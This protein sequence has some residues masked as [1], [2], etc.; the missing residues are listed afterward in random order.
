MIDDKEIGG[1]RD[2]ETSKE[3]CVSNRSTD[4]STKRP[5]LTGDD[6]TDGESHAETSSEHCLSSKSTKQP[7]LIF[8]DEQQT[9]SD[10]GGRHSPMDRSPSVGSPQR[11]E[12]SKINTHPVRRCE[13]SAHMADGASEEGNAEVS[14][15]VSNLPL[16]LPYRRSREAR[17]SIW[18]GDPMITSERALS[19]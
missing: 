5:R 13:R 9:P 15:P 10:L 14:H 2:K 1:D 4:T 7:L 18:E 6:E 16:S 8:D 11:F 19:S 12:S 3:H 17:E